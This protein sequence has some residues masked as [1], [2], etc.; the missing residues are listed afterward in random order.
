M[1][2]NSTAALSNF[3]T[4]SMCPPPKKAQTPFSPTQASQT[5]LSTLIR[6]ENDG[7]QP[8]AERKQKYSRSL[9]SK[10]YLS[11]IFTLHDAYSVAIQTPDLSDKETPDVL[12]NDSWT[13]FK[14]FDPS[15]RY[16][17]IPEP[18]GIRV[19]FPSPESVTCT[20]IEDDYTAA[21]NHIQM[22]FEPTVSAP[23]NYYDAFNVST[24]K[25]Y[26][27]KGN[28]PPYY[29]LAKRSDVMWGNKPDLGASIAGGELS[30]R[31]AQYFVNN[32]NVEGRNEKHC[33]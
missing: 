11:R 9:E 23:K 27:W 3:S 16:E 18:L 12:A 22:I 21:S 19:E 10:P 15:E 20:T 30:A 28:A 29:S 26:A 33:L 2:K 8:N 13:N 32:L 1:T 31:D 7:L 25:P 17:F 6:L 5:P 24:V 14:P 4:V